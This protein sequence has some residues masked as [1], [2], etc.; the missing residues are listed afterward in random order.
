MTGKVVSRDRGVLRETYLF[1]TLGDDTPGGLNLELL[2][3]RVSRPHPLFPGVF[4]DDAFCAIV[5]PLL[6]G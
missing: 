3:L 5:R 2:G 1:D 6:V 4:N